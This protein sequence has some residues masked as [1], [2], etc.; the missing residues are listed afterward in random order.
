MRPL[1][2]LPAR[3]VRRAPPGCSPSGRW[4]ITRWVQGWPQ[5]RRRAADADALDAV[6]RETLQSLFNWA[7]KNSD[8]EKLADMARRVRDG[9]RVD[10]GALPD[11][12]GASARAVP[13]QSRW[14]TEELE[15]KRRD[16]REVLDALSRQPTEA[17]YI[18]LATGMYTNASLPKED[19]ILA[20]DELKELVRQID[21][22]S[23]LPL[24][25]RL[26]GLRRPR[27]PGTETRTSPPPPP[28]PSPSP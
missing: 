5:I 21:N 17:Q 2:L 24:A 23:D 10:V 6:P 4:S 13:N 14:T 8:P 11:P 16:V 22:A 28:P 7:I 12:R 27:L 1:L 9:E 3:S 26:T 19:R 20:L 15:Q 18:K 25:G